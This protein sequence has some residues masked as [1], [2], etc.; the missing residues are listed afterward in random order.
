MPISPNDPRPSY[1]QIA[2]H[3]RK[4]IESGELAPGQRLPSGRQMAE[5]YGVAAMT[6]QQAIGELGDLV[7]RWQGRGVFVREHDSTSGS[8]ES[9][10]VQDVVDHLAALR[11]SFENLESRVAKLEAQRTRQS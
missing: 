11:A 3:L 2:D 5:E 6:V 8:S 7:V 10:T 9:L 4:K 1:V